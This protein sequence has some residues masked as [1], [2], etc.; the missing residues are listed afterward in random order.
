MRKLLDHFR[1]VHQVVITDRTAKRLAD[2]VLAM[3]DV[4]PGVLLGVT[5]S[6]LSALLPRRVDVPLSELRQALA[7][8]RA[9]VA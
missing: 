6:D 1:R 3:K 8:G 4:D 5:G 9:H 2:T 7:G